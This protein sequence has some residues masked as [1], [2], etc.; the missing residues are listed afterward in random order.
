MFL[1]GSTLPRKNPLSSSRLKYA[2]FLKVWRM[3]AITTPTRSILTGLTNE[4]WAERMKWLMFAKTF[5]LELGFC[6]SVPFLRRL[7]AQDLGG[8]HVQW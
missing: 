1:N 2:I 4:T 8:R 6:S 5:K 7:C 3:L